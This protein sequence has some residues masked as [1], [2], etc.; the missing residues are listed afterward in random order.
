MEAILGNYLDQI[1]IGGKQIYK[2]LAL[3]PLL[4]N[5][6]I[7]LEYLNLDEAL[8]GSL[9]EVTEKTEGGSV[10]ELQVVNKSSQMVLIL[11]GEELV[12]AKQTRIINTTILVPGLVTLGHT[13]QLCGAGPLG[14]VYSLFFQPGADH[15][16]QYQG[17]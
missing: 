13:G 12:G 10:P 15:A 6:A 9:K 1:K 4:Y 2:N 8:Q 16:G 11:D 5:L 14:P 7:P 17:Q 3:F